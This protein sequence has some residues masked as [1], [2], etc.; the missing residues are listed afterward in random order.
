MIQSFL[1]GKLGRRED[2]GFV[3]GPG[4]DRERAEGTVI[5]LLPE[6]LQFIAHKY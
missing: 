2:D 4:G 5:D 6:C 1:K 3:E